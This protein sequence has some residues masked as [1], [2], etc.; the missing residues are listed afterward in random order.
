MNI[1]NW[2]MKL[3]PAAWRERYEAEMRA[4]LDDHK[5]TFFTIFDL[6]FG[7]L[8][9]RMD[10]YY[11]SET[12][13]FAL[14]RLRVNNVVFIYALAIAFCCISLW[15]TFVVVGVVPPFF[16]SPGLH[17]LPPPPASLVIA[18]NSAQFLF[19]LLVLSNLFI[20]I[21]YVRQAIV[22]RQRG[23]L[24]LAA[25]CF[26]LPII[27]I[28]MIPA[29]AFD[30]RYGFWSLYYTVVQIIG[31][32]LLLGNVVLLV[33]KLRASITT[34][35]FRLAFFIILT[36]L[37]FFVVP[38]L[39]HLS[40]F[41]VYTYPPNQAPPFGLSTVATFGAILWEGQAPFAALATLVLFITCTQ[42]TKRAAR[43]VF[44]FAG[45]VMLTMVLHIIASLIWYVNQLVQGQIRDSWIVSLVTTAIVSLVAIGI[46][47][48]AL[49]K[50]FV[51]LTHAYVS[52]TEN[53]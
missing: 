37:L 42:L 18:E 48:V 39:L 49:R 10:P 26:V 47:L 9:A 6:L 44:V 27:I 21:S 2:I 34:G 29:F 52:P 22:A 53:M 50:G 1:I 46:A 13:F 31:A 28:E 5:I 3:Y 38:A 43:A 7:A 35:R 33:S 23:R 40:Y 24:L 36:E 16:Q 15:S 11:N 51:A 30:I 12:A 17:H 41:N 45:L 4:V 14:K 20:L 8:D 19:L 32:E 25:I